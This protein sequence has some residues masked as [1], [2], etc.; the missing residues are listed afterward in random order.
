MRKKNLKIASIIILGLTGVIFTYLMFNMYKTEKKLAETMLQKSMNN[1]VSNLKAFFEPVKSELLSIREQAQNGLFDSITPA[2]MN[3]YF[4][5]IIGNFSQISSMGI[6]NTE[7]FEFDVLPNDSLIE[8]RLVWVNKLGWI[9]K[10]QRWQNFPSQNRRLLIQEWEKSLK[11]DPRNRSW[12]VGA[13][14]AKLG[15][16]SWTQPYTYNTTFQI[17]MTASVRWP[18]FKGDKQWILALDLTL[19]D[20]TKFT[21]KRKVSKNGKVFVLSNDNRYIGLPRDEKFSSEVLINRALFQKVDST[22]EMSVKNANRYWNSS[23]N[24]NESFE[25]E[26]EGKTWWG[27]MNRF[28]LSP[29]NS[30]TVGVIIPDVDILNE[31]KNM[32]RVMLVGFVFILILIGFTLYANGQSQHAFRLLSIKNEEINRQKMLIQKKGDEINDSINYAKRIQRAILPRNNEIKKKLENSFILFKPKDIVAG[33]FYWLE[34]KDD[35]TFF[36]VAD[37]TGHG[38]PGA[39]VSVICKNALS[40]SVRE[41][42]VIDPGQI[43]NETRKMIIQEFDTSSEGVKDGMDIAL[44]A[45]KNNQLKYAGANNP[46]WIIRKGS[47]SIEMYKANKQPVGIYDYATDFDTHDVRLNTGDTLYLFSDGYRD[48]FGGQNGKKYMSSKF[49]K[50]LLSIQNEN[51]DR[52]LELLD[53]EFEN[54]KGDLQQLDDVCVMGVRI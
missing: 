25:F 1:T 26:S 2:F 23:Q 24:T 42:E 14:N 33:D 54:W 12:F 41:S 28:E 31:V 30:L 37:C 53:H 10:W 16:I 6:A 8:N 15:N 51:M 20:I 19:L 18:D 21:Q 44:C 5:P 43:L 9:E 3:S 45:M 17:G 34:E 36:A 27:K 46:L 22:G 13:M 32:K 35:W 39:M 11:Q 50:F 40:R 52:Q 4:E 47:T 7:G 38:I 49:I 48:Q 29:G